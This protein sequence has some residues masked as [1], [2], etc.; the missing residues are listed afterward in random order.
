[1]L[2]RRKYLKL[3]HTAALILLL[4]IDQRHIARTPSTSFYKSH[5]IVSYIAFALLLCVPF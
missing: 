4:Q 5:S 3:D 1:M 2:Q